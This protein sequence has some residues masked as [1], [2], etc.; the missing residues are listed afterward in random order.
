MIIG[1][2]CKMVRIPIR[3]MNSYLFLNKIKMIV[4]TRVE[5]LEMA[6]EKIVF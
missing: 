1:E 4:T 2:K 6:C 3:N 5:D